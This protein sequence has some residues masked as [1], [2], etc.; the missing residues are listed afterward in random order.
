MQ[1]LTKPSYFSQDYV[2]ANCPSFK[3]RYSLPGKEKCRG[4]NI[5]CT[6]L[7]T[8]QYR[9]FGICRVT[10]RLVPRRIC[11][12]IKHDQLKIYFDKCGGAITVFHCISNC[13]AFAIW[14][15]KALNNSQAKRMFSF[16]IFNQFQIACLLHKTSHPGYLVC[17]LNKINSVNQERFWSCHGHWFW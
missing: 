11:V 10:V 17:Y 9:V 12:S 1:M 16:S 4:V 5:H 3:H 8:T 2:K 14:L 7:P 6:N 15:R 13:N